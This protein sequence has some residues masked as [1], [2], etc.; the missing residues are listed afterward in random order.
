MSGT[1]LLLDVVVTFTFP[2]TSF[3]LD[4][5]FYVL[6]LHVFVIF[7]IKSADGDISYVELLLLLRHKKSGLTH[8]PA[9]NTLSSG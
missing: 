5:Y 1:G 7:E 4:D 8:Y 6:F 3:S 9:A 2:F